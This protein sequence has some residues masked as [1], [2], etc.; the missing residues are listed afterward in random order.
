MRIEKSA[1]KETNRQDIYCLYTELLKDATV[2]QK[3]KAL[4]AAAAFL[5]GAAEKQPKSKST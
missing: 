4:I 2:E 1:K 5:M 3:E